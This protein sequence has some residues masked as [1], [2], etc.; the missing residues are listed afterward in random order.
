MS[1]ITTIYD[2]AL[3][4]LAATFPDHQK[5]EQPYL[6]E[7]NDDMVLRRGY[8][9]TMGPAEHTNRAV[10]CYYSVRRSA[11]ITLSVANHGTDR[12]A[13]IRETA[14]KLLM[15]DMVT[16]AKACDRDPALNQSCSYFRYSADSGVEFVV[17]DNDN[18][19]MLRAEFSFEYLEE[20]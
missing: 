6:P 12:D 5:M 19:L 18:F 20:A 16:L 3:T 1:A 17:T 8:G 4:L 11:F 7:M 15:E 14:E 10:D 2:N 9:I 13:A